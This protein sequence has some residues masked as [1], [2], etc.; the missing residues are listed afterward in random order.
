M[1]IMV[2]FESFKKIKTW[3]K[4]L[5]VG[6]KDAVRDTGRQLTIQAEK[7]AKERIRTPS[8]KPGKREGEYF[9]SIQSEFK[10]GSI[11][12]TGSLKSE[13]A[14]AGIIEFGSRPHIIRAKGNKLLFWPGATHPV[15]EVMHPGTPAFRVLGDAVEDASL[16]EKEKLEQVL[17]KH[18]VP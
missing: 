16:Q 10:E 6:M 7:I 15:K 14:L 12:F 4:N 3:F 18:F 11:S 13:S 9:Q 2:R 1:S 8:R 17:K 5:S